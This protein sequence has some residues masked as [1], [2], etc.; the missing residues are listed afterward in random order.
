M[1][2]CLRMRVLPMRSSLQRAVTQ[3][4]QRTVWKPSLPSGAAIA[5]PDDREAAIAFVVERGY[6]P[7]TAQAVV[8]SL[9]SPEWNARSVG[10]VLALASKLAGAW[11]IGEDAGLKSLAVSIER[12]RLASEGKELV[13]FFVEPVRGATFSCQAYEGLSLRDV[14]EHGE[15]EGARLLAE[16]L[17]CACSGVMACSTCHVYVDEAWLAAVGA[18]SDAEEDMLDLAYQP[19]DNS[20]LACQLV[21]RPELDGMRILL[22]GVLGTPAAL[23]LLPQRASAG[24]HARACACARALCL[25]HLGSHVHIT[26]T[27]RACLRSQLHRHAH[28]HAHHVRAYARDFI[29]VDAFCAFPYTRGGRHCPGCLLA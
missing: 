21:L 7:S 24:V 3:Q 16:H 14:A 6:S 28:A 26:S 25:A 12:A 4:T 9:E 15:D 13:Q 22:P 10:G 18:P 20:R 8:E 11:E 5:P 23:L 27:S 2:A 19:R 17:E 1:L 29:D